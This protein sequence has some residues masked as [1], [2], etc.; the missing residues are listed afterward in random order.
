MPFRIF[1]CGNSCC[2]SQNLH[3]IFT[4]KCLF[5]WKDSSTMNR[6]VTG[7]AGCMQVQKKGKRQ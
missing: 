1:F 7:R 2:R 6:K 4:I 3:K 5:S